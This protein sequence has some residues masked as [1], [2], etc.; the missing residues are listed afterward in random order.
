MRSII[1]HVATSLDGYI[2]HPDGS[3]HGFL[4][5]GEHI[6]EYLESL[7]EYDTVIMGRNTYT[8]GYSFGLKPGE[9]AY[10]HMRHYIFSRT[11]RFEH[12]HPQV[13]IVHEKALETVQKLLNE[14]GSPIYLCGGGSFAGFLLREGLIDQVLVKLNPVCFGTGIPLFGDYE[15]VLNLELLQQKMYP[16]GVLLIRY[17]VQKEE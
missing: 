17:R 9:P 3:T 12:A 15:D 13:E 14:E 6:P 10:P 7:K 16:K 1:Y 11:L 2:A 8:S 5:E 4:E